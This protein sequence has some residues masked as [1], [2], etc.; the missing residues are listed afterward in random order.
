MHGRD[1]PRWVQT[2]RTEVATSVMYLYIQAQSLGASIRLPPCT[3]AALLS[4]AS[5]PTSPTRNTNRDGSTQSR[6]V[7]RFHMV[8][9]Y[10]RIG[11]TG[12]RVPCGDESQKESW[13]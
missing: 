12:H 7:Q 8:D 4:P 10:C 3:T 6:E 13:D 2:T 11:R 1:G 9:L 5:I